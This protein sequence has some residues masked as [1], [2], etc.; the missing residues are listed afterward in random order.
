M[1]PLSELAN[2]PLQNVVRYIRQAR[3]GSLL[4]AHDPVLDRATGA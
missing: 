3:V 1:D 4:E 2:D